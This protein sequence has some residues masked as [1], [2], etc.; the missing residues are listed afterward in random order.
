MDNN[1]T[2]LLNVS[3]ATGAKYRD[4]GGL[5]ESLLAVI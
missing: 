3:G 1:L 2:M 5:P 4:V